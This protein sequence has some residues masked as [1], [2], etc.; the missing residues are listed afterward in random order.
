MNINRIKVINNN[1]GEETNRINGNID[2][3]EPKIIT[4][5]NLEIFDKNNNIINDIRN[6][7]LLINKKEKLNCWNYFKYLISFKKNNQDIKH[8]EDLR[9]LIISEECMTQNF[10]NIYNLLQIHHLI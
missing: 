6:N 4:E 9:R 10:L 1:L 3:R 5:H 7:F 8:Y 2:N